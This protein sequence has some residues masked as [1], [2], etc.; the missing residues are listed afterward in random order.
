VKASP[1]RGRDRPFLSQK[2]PL[3]VLCT[4]VDAAHLSLTRTSRNQKV[5]RIKNMA[6][7]LIPCW[8]PSMQ[9]NILPEKQSISGYRY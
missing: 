6:A 3:V 7:T 5:G 2:V 4:Q 8:F 9:Q 1:H